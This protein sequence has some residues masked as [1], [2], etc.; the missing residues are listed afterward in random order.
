[1]PKA[2][3]R[4]GTCTELTGRT[5]R[6]GLY[7]ATGRPVRLHLYRLDMHFGPLASAARSRDPTAGPDPTPA[8]AANHTWETEGVG[9]I[10]DCHLK[11]RAKCVGSG[12]VRCSL[13]RPCWAASRV[14]PTSGSGRLGPRATNGSPSGVGS[15][16]G[17]LHAPRG[18]EPLSASYPPPP[19][20]RIR[21]NLPKKERGSRG[22]PLF[23][24]PRS[25]PESRPRKGSGKR[26]RVQLFTT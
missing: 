3:G 18:H 17:G 14:C 5:P 6:R 20:F 11:A 12:G 15:Y 10:F 4:T 1:M 9:V 22:I 13:R 8:N 16:L 24:T 26:R 7:C 21:T 19:T 23:K 2:V 25:F